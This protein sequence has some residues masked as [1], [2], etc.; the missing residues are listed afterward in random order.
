M[1]KKS[2]CTYFVCGHSILFQKKLNIIKN[3]S[4]KTIVFL[5]S[6]YKCFWT[7]FAFLRIY[8][9]VEQGQG[10]SDWSSTSL[11][12]PTACKYRIWF[13]IK[14]CILSYNSTKIHVWK[15]ILSWDVVT[16]S[17]TRI[18]FFIQQLFIFTSCFLVVKKFSRVMDNCTF[19]SR[20][21]CYTP[22]RLVF[23]F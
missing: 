22:L 12:W 6:Y 19:I 18:S 23:F 7:A 21:T 13:D 3:F 9:A 15:K 16:N 14:L 1:N 10:K 8:C 4:F 11:L 2:L 20:L 17:E 5:Y